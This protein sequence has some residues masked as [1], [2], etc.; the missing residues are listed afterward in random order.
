MPVPFLQLRGL[1]SIISIFFI[2]SYRPCVNDTLVTTYTS[3]LKLESQIQ[4]GCT[5]AHN[6]PDPILN[7]TT[8]TT[9]NIFAKF[10]WMR[11]KICRYT[12]IS[13]I[14][15]RLLSSLWWKI[16]R[17]NKLNSHSSEHL[18]VPLLPVPQELQDRLKKATFFF[19]LRVTTLTS[20]SN[21]DTLVDPFYHS[22]KCVD[23]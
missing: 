9:R 23:T 17:K 4:V 11:L 8:T 12:S 13:S 15:Y 10:G 3:N 19:L 21:F 2:V 16:V 5:S 18:W 1:I 14:Y 20:T 22:P 6:D 7:T